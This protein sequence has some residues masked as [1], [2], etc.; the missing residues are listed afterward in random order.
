MKAIATM[1]ALLGT[2][3]AALSH[4]HVSEPALLVLSGA[5]LLGLASLVRR[6]LPAEL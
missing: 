1:I 2:P 4:A 3:A 6:S 5:T